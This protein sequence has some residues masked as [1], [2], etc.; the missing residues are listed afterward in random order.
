MRQHWTL[1]ALALACLGLL[2]CG[3]DSTTNDVAPAIGQPT[4]TCGPWLGDENTDYDGDFLQSIEV[5]VSDASGDL[6]TVTAT[7]RGTV[8]EL[9]GDE[10]G[11][12]TVNTVDTPGALLRC[13]PPA[14]LLIRALDAAGHVTELLIEEM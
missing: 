1:A 4:V 8:L 11:L 9:T 6:T 10:A 14:P 7:W 5:T 3:D 2:A 13:E 12:Y